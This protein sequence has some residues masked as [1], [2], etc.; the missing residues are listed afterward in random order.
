M[1]ALRARG[2]V[3]A[4]AGPAL[5][6]GYGHAGAGRQAN[7]AGT[8]TVTLTITYTATLLF[9]V[10]VKCTVSLIVLPH[11][12]PNHANEGGQSAAGGPAA[13]CSCCC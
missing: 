10:Y 6:G 1:R 13:W 5:P 3:W 2:T 7:E 12:A 11:S 9:L 8:G 4:K